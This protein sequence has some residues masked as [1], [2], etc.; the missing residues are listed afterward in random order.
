[1][2]VNLL[3]TPLRQNLMFAKCTVYTVYDFAFYLYTHCPLQK[4]AVVM[5]NLQRVAVHYGLCE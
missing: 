1:M 3:L 5:E 4:M 2:S